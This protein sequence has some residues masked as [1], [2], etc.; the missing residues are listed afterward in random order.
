ML[1]ENMLRALVYFFSAAACGIVLGVILRFV[2]RA[3]HPFAMKVWKFIG[4]AFAAIK[5][6]M[7]V[8]RNGGCS[9]QDSLHYLKA[10]FRI[11]ASANQGRACAHDAATALVALNAFQ[12]G[13]AAIAH[14]QY[15]NIKHTQE[16]ELFSQ[17]TPIDFVRAIIHLRTQ[18]G[19]LFV[20][21]QALDC[22]AA[23]SRFNLLESFVNGV[24][25][26]KNAD[27]NWANYNQLLQTVHQPRAQHTNDFF[28]QRAREILQLNPTG[29]RAPAVHAGQSAP[30]VRF[31]A[32]QPNTLPLKQFVRDVEESFVGGSFATF[33]QTLPENYRH[34]G[35]ALVTAIDEVLRNFESP[36]SQTP[37][38]QRH[39]FRTE[40]HYIVNL[41]RQ[42]PAHVIWMN[43]IAANASA[44]CENA[45]RLGLIEIFAW[46]QV[47]R[48]DSPADKVA[49]CHYVKL[50]HLARESAYTLFAQRRIP[51]I[52]IPE[53]AGAMIYESYLILQRDR[54]NLRWLGLYPHATNM[55][56]DWME[57]FQNMTTERFMRTEASQKL[58]RG[59]AGQIMQ[60][61]FDT[62]KD[63][64]I[65][66]ASVSAILTHPQYYTE[67]LAG[68]LAGKNMADTALSFV[69]QEPNALVEAFQDLG[70]AEAI[71]LR[72]FL[73][74][75]V[76]LG[77]IA[78]LAASRA[79]TAPQTQ[80]L[81]MHIN[82]FLECHD[83][84]LLMTIQQLFSNARAETEL[85]QW[86]RPDAMNA[87]TA[88]RQKI[89]NDIRD[90][91]HQTFIANLSD[92]QPQ[93]SQNMRLR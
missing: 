64:F 61:N 77:N 54:P 80:A 18:Y 31:Q 11:A 33:I 38:Q 83:I 30:V 49:A 26:L 51:G 72:D 13:R 25:L 32:Q 59:F 55:S 56:L 37:M 60:S 69:I 29:P 75:H 19:D 87:I 4:D 89:D 41:L 17:T 66:C 22:L 92:A 15:Q 52:Y 42:E 5:A 62:L 6:A 82:D 78:Q 40:L 34:N 76:F 20:N 3:L 67:C 24:C 14:P 71:S 10:F 74:E 1:S 73:K 35:G 2:L 50:V 79:R 53:I 23:A 90:L 86:V 43:D 12:F 9:L 63:F 36:E 84:S 21:E 8:Y 85:H 47:A 7:L 46:T 88:Y 93:G 44:G 81:M 39:D 70:P 65:S 27:R 68:S 58:C 57:P 91:V 28:E 45:S 16:R 48:Q